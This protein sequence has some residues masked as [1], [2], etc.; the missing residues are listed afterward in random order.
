MLLLLNTFLYRTHSNLNDSQAS[1]NLATEAE[2]LS[3]EYEAQEEEE[4]TTTD[5]LP[6]PNPDINIE[7]DR[8]SHTNQAA[9]D[10]SAVNNK[11]ETNKSVHETIRLFQNKKQKR[12]ND[13]PTHQMVKIMKENSDF[14]K[15]RYE[16]KSMTAT[17]SNKPSFLETLDDTDLFFLSMSRMTKKLPKA[18]QAQIKLALSNSVLTAE[19]RAN[20]QE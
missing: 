9:E 8:H 14:R 15:H 5:S 4:S 19:L 7:N 3:D 11:T 1:A 2:D 17:A 6:K 20:N 10:Q 12:P 18:E 16:Q 13:S